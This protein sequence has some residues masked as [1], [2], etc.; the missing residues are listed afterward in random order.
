MTTEAASAEM[1]ALLC[2]CTCRH[3]GGSDYAKK[4]VQHLKPTHAIPLH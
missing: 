2:I 1:K 3:D 4:T